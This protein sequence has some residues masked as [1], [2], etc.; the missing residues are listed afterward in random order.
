VIASDKHTRKTPW[1][2][3]T[4]NTDPLEYKDEFWFS[5][6][7]VVIPNQKKKKDEIMYAFHDILA[8]GHLG[9]DKTYKAISRHFW[10]PHIRQEVNKYVQTCESC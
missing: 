1:F 6:E 5:R 10:W 7:A 9:R 4:S 2:Q 8:A 3:K